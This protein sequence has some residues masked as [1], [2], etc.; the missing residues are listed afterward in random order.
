VTILTLVRHGQ[1]DWNLARRIQGETDVPLNDTGRRQAGDA[2]SALAEML[3]LTRPTVVV[4][5][6]LSRAGETAEIIADRLGLDAPRKRYRELRERAYGEAEGVFIEDFLA[7][8]GSWDRD[9]IPGAETRPELRARGVRALRRVARDVRSESAPTAA[10]V[11]VVAHG[12]LIGE[13]IRHASGDTLPLAGERIEN[14][15]AHMFHIDGDALRL[16]SYSAV[17]AA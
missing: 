17:A 12:A 10:S 9:N 5:S 8:F 14:G 13:M 6:D 7:R 11:I 2:A 4:A 15:S 16:L 1:T 3:D